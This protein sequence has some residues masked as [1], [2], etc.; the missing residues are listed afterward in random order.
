MKVQIKSNINLVELFEGVTDKMKIELQQ[1][2]AQTVLDIRNNANFPFDTGALNRSVNG[3]YKETEFGAT[4]IIDAGSRYAAYQEF[5]TI[6]KFD[7]SYTSE[8]GLTSYASQ[9]KGKGIIKTGG[10]PA[11]RYFF[12]PVRRKFEELLKTLNKTLND[13]R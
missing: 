2:G 7:P 5:G 6:L 9:F 10:V 13:S 1:W 3:Q 11:R 4:Y 12:R 8:L